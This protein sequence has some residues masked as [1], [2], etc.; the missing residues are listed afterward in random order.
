MQNKI[1]REIKNQ[2]LEIEQEETTTSLWGDKV[3]FKPHLVKVEGTDCQ[4]LIS[5]GSM[6]DRPYYWLVL[7]SSSWDIMDDNFT[8]NLRNEPY[9]RE[10][11]VNLA[12][13]EQ[14]GFYPY[15]DDE[16]EE[17]EV[18]EYPAI[19]REGIGHWGLVINF[20]TGKY[21]SLDS[22]AEKLL[23][24]HYPELLERQ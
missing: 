11:A 12:I 3:T 17:V 22:R 21:N 16:G 2:I 15:E 24:K 7:I 8:D 5:V 23:L 20:K 18:E 4:Q 1:S 9:S 14:C 6:D 19:S 10:E 13:E